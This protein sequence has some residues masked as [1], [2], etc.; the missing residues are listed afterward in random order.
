MF[1]TRPSF[2]LLPLLCF[3]ML[4]G[5]AC[6]SASEKYE[7]DASHAAAL[8]RINHFGISYTYGRFNKISG[9]F[10]FDPKDPEKSSISIEIKADSIDSNSAKRDTH[11][12]GPDFFNV[13]QFPVITFKS[14]GIK[15]AGEKHFDVTGNFSLH[16]VTK[17]IT[18]KVEHVGAKAGPDKKFRRGFD[19]VFTIK[20]SDYGMKGFLP[21]IGDEV[22]ITLGMEGVRQ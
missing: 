17:S 2:R 7:V 5:P 13:K 18:V 19:T 6:L 8:F 9:S 15:K 16:G 14:T 1:K 4:A 3:L 21:A 22:Q 20:R 12:R 10:T 11:L